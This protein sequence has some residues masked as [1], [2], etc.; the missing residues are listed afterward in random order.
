[1]NTNHETEPV[2]T[3]VTATGVPLRCAAHPENIRADPYEGD[4]DQDCASSLPFAPHR[5]SERDETLSEESD[6]NHP[7]DNN[8]ADRKVVWNNKEQSHHWS[9]TF[10]RCTR[11]D[12]ERIRTN[13]S[14]SNEVMTAVTAKEAGESG[15][16]H[17]QGHIHV[18]G[19][20]R[21]SGV[22]SL[23]DQVSHACI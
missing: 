6:S 13:P 1:M 17:L 20:K 23:L 16:P 10:N 22:H 5:N 9:L 18:K 4:H 21:Q 19:R 15:T 14:D 2:P 8:D 3:D 12:E 7:Y 11:E